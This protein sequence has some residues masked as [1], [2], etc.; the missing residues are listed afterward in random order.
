MIYDIIKAVDDG[1]PSKEIMNTV[2]AQ[3]IEVLSSW[4]WKVHNDTVG[5][6]QT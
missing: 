3:R 2:K 1:V 6:E 4:F 5:G